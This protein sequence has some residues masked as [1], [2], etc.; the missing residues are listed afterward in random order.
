MSKD[1]RPS[2]EELEQ[3]GETGSAQ[4]QS[5]LPPSGTRT[6]A[7]AA[8]KEGLRAKIWDKITSQVIIAIFAGLAAV[9]PILWSFFQDLSALVWSV[10]II[11]IILGFLSLLGIDHFTDDLTIQRKWGIHIVLAAIFVGLI[12]ALVAMLQSIDSDHS[13]TLKAQGRA[14]ESDLQKQLQKAQNDL[15][16]TR[17][18]EE[19][20][21]QKRFTL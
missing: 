10:A 4:K 17:E 21:D 1:V 12:M 20:T 2:G 16:R 18:M 8:A 3:P 13:A 9:A 15:R 11:A 5:F 6:A 19:T 7:P 14:R